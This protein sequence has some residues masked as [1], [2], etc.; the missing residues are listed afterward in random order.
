MLRFGS[1]E[2]LGTGSSI[3]PPQIEFDE[4]APAVWEVFVAELAKNGLEPRMDGYRGED[5]G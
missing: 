5:Q 2:L 3:W 1:P 4:E